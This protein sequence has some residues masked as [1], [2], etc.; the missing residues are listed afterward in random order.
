MSDS[1]VPV[2]SCWKLSDTLSRPV[3]LCPTL[4]NEFFFYYLNG[5]SFK[6]MSIKGYFSQPSTFINGT[7]SDRELKTIELK[8]VLWCHRN[9]IWWMFSCN[10]F[11]GNGHNSQ[12]YCS[13]KWKL[14]E[15][16]W[17]GKYEPSPKLISAIKF[18][19][20]NPKLNKMFY[21]TVFQ[22]CNLEFIS[23]I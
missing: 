2:T 23:C 6:E 12:G 16:Q 18:I 15:T 7:N 20:S 9:K 10:Q 13:S 4:F 1:W 19:Y 17:D 3:T 8:L 14:N 21:N 11:Y 5:K 22:P